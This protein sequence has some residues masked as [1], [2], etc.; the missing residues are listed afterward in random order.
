MAY[1]I[2]RLTDSDVA[3]VRSAPWDL[4]QAA[5]VDWFHYWATEA[6]KH[7]QGMEAVR[8]VALLVQCRERVRAMCPDRFQLAADMAMFRL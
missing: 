1:E 2:D 4:G 3:I 8:E 5:V 7:Q 6:V